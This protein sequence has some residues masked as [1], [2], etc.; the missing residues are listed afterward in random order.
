MTYLQR[1]KKLSYLLKPI[2][3][4]QDAN[5]AVA[6][7]LRSR[8]DDFDILLVK[9]ATNA[10]D[11]WSGQIALPGGKSESEDLTLEATVERE[12]F[13]ETGIDLRSS[14]FLGVLK[15]VRSV[16]KHGLL[17]LPFITLISN[18]PKI[19][20]NT[21]ELESYFWVPCAKIRNSKGTILQPEVGEVP[22]FILEKAVVWGITHEILTNLLE[23]LE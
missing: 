7:I 13:E 17:V 8:K 15:V 12:T 19:R 14:K 6:V 2:T 16:L 4:E 20:L 5:A 18:E 10:K 23:K 1:I 9:R 22:A 3:E 21:V 11:V